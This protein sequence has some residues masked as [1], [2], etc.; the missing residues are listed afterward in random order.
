MVPS[1]S[2]S[3]GNPVINTGLKVIDS[4]THSDSNSDS[5]SD[6]DSDSGFEWYVIRTRMATMS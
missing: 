6:S 5:D 3:G 2:D 4:D 1:N